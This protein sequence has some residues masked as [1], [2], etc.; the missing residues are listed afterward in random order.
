MLLTS[1]WVPECLP[2][3]VIHNVTWLS[4]E[5]LGKVWARSGQDDSTWFYHQRL[6]SSFS[7]SRRCVDFRS[8]ALPFSVSK[9]FS[10][11]AWAVK[12]TH[13]RKLEEWFLTSPFL[14]VT[15]KLQH[16]F[17]SAFLDYGIGQHI[18]SSTFIAAGLKGCSSRYS[19]KTGWNW[20]F[21]VLRSTSESKWYMTESNSVHDL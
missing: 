3:V 15:D 4:P 20:C 17:G 18:H 9:S 2:T 7:S 19:P 12:T 10:V 13:G 5:G 1:S 21:S 16:R 8:W 6:A 11:M 14:T